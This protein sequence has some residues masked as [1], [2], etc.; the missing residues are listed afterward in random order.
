MAGIYIKQ[1]E[2]RMQDT[3]NNHLQVQRGNPVRTFS[4]TD[5]KKNH[6][7]KSFKKQRNDLKKEL[8]NEKNDLN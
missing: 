2:K 6:Q 5:F 1:L 3:W 7:D 8:K 4:G